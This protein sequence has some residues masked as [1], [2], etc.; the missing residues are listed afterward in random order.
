MQAVNTSV[1]GQL[2]EVELEVCEASP[3]ADDPLW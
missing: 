2:N 1:C 3:S